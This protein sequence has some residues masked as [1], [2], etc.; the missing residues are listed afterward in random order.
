MTFGI[1]GL[2]GDCFIIDDPLKPV[3]A[4][5]DAQRNAVNDWFSNTL[6]SRFDNKQRGSSSS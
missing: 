6:S 2:G 4:Q 1:T 5:S 3:D